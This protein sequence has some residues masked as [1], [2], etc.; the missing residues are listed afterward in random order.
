MTALRIVLVLLLLVPG[1]SA[2]AQT[3]PDPQSLIGEWAGLVTLVG[4]RAAASRSAYTLSIEKVEGE[5]AYGRA[6]TPGGGPPANF[7]GTL[8]ANTLTFYTG[9]FEIALTVAG[10][11]M[12]GQSRYGG[13]S[14]VELGL[15]KVEKK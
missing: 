3:A 2:L 4:G 6:D 13:D 9:R 5:H 14:T 12:Y 11:R 10:K 15:E 8:R 1:S 7:V